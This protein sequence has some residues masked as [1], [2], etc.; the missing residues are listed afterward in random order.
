MLST[1]NVLNSSTWMWLQYPVATGSVSNLAA[2]GGKALIHGLA[3]GV[4]VL[5]GPFDYFCRLGWRRGWGWHNVKFSPRVDGRRHLNTLG[6]IGGLTQ[7][8]PGQL[9]QLPGLSLSISHRL[10]PRLFV[11]D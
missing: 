7:L 5:P 10:V 9:R 1:S 3:G 6:D 11:V 2:E 8:D 4:D